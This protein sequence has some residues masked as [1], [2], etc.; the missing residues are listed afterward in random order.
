MRN[1][2]QECILIVYRELEQMRPSWYSSTS[3]RVYI[4]VNGDTPYG[5]YYYIRVW[6]HMSIFIPVF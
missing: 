3:M 1:F 6:I 4:S 2:W 5:S